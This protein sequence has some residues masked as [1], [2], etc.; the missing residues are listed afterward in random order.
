MCAHTF[1][2]FVCTRAHREAIKCSG[3]GLCSPVKGK[4]GK[5][6]LCQ[7]GFVTSD[8][9]SGKFC[10][11]VDP[12]A[13]SSISGLKDNDKGKLSQK[14]V[15][16]VLTYGISGFVGL[17]VLC[18][19]LY[20]IITYRRR[21]TET[22]RKTVIEFPQPQLELP[23]EH[24]ADANVMIPDESG[25]TNQKVLQHSNFMLSVCLGYC[26][27]SCLRHVCERSVL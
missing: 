17:V 9:A 18:V 1:A 5:E 10:D 15:R 14:M 4:E 2:L 24:R 3:H 6:C 11:K 25:W 19:A 20:L 27:I 7:T 16:K 8:P 13:T 23:A 21:Q 12:N 22:I 26:K